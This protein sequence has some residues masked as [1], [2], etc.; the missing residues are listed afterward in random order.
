MRRTIPYLL[1]LT[2][3]LVPATGHAQQKSKLIPLKLQVVF[4]E[5]EG[6]KKVSSIPYMLSV[7]AGEEARGAGSKI[8]VGVRVPLLVQMKEGAQT[9]YQNVGTDIDSFA[10]SLG[11]GNFK[12]ILSVSR[13]FVYSPGGKLG[14]LMPDQQVSTTPI[15][16]DF[17]AEFDLL[18][19]DGQTVQ[20]AMATD[21]VS[22]R[23]LK[24]DVTIT[25]VK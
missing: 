21:P 1:L 2:V 9:Q 24:V 10:Q 20:S 14:D 15:F 18:L 5:F 19:K 13:S 22:G 4:S 7:T 8:R 16:R 11:D 23:V 17:R 6:E 25:L 3:L 12:I